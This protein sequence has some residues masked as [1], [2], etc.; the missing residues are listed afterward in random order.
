MLCLVKLGI[1]CLFFFFFFLYTRI[2]KECG[3]LG[4]GCIFKP[5]INEDCFNHPGMFGLKKMSGHATA[6]E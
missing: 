3:R 6:R 2:W 1:L 4:V 5:S